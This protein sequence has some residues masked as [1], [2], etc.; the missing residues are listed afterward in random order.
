M[1]TRAPLRENPRRSTVAFG[2]RLS[3]AWNSIAGEFVFDEQKFV[4]VRPN[5]L[6][7]PVDLLRS[8][9]QLWRECRPGLVC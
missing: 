3:P 1:A 8:L 7:E 2:E 4:A 6:L 5:T 9:Y